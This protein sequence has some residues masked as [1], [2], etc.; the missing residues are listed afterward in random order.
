MKKIMVALLILV[1]T[2][3]GCSSN[4]KKET[5][6]KDKESNSTKIVQTFLEHSYTE[7]DI[8]Q[9]DKFEDY[10]SKQLQNKV[11]D[12]KQTFDD[13]GITKDIES[14]KVFKDTDNSKKYM[15]DIKVKTTNDNVKNIDYNERYGIVKLKNED[16]KTKISDLKE[17]GSETYNGGD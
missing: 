2:L 16:G 12:Q 3:V 13:N 6:N 8:K 4:E 5:S 17:V 7:N 10:T 15:Y 9:W 11:E 14:I 1:L